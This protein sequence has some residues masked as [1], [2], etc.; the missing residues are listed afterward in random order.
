MKRKLLLVSVVVCGGYFVNVSAQGYLTDTRTSNAMQMRDPA[1]QASVEVDAAVVNPAGTAFMNDGLHLSASG[2]ASFQTIDTKTAG[3]KYTGETKETQWLPAVQL[4]YKKNRWAVS[5]SFANE[6]GS[7]RRKTAHGSSWNNTFLGNQTYINSL[8]DELSESFSACSRYLRILDVL[9]GNKLGI[10]SRQ[11]DELSVMADD[12]KTT[13]YNKAIRAGVSYRMTDKLSFYLGAKANYVSIKGS[14]NLGITVFRPS[15]GE[16]IGLQNYISLD[17][18]AVS[19]LNFDDDSKQKIQETITNLNQQAE[20]LGTV[21]ENIGYTGYSVRGWGFAPVIGIDYKTG[22]FNFG[23]KYE[24]ASHINS[25]SD[26]R[27]SDFNI[28]ALLSLGGSWQCSDKLKFA[29]GGN[30]VFSEDKTWFGH[31]ESS[32]AWDASISATYDIND[33]VS[34]SG[35]Y[36]LGS[37]SFVAPE[38]IPIILEASEPL[39]H[40]LSFGAAWNILKNMQVNAGMSVGMPVHRINVSWAGDYEGKSS[41]RYKL[42]TQFALGVNYSF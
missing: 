13:E 22:A 21:A 8:L 1:R 16:Y 6:G 11:E 29:L 17:K 39:T 33:K 19:D 35:G 36:T 30:I 7:G 27:A 40:K 5:A 28:P 34:V 41:Y 26:C 10:D 32:V 3:G 18:E 4:V 37:A 38:Y 42:M 23:A 9:Y 24:F 20:E 2:F 15:S 31:Q 25:S 14:T 12:I